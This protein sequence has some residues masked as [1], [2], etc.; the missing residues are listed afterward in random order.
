MKPRPNRRKNSD[1]LDNAPLRLSEHNPFDSQ[2][3]SPHGGTR[4]VLIFLGL[5][6]VAFLVFHNVVPF[7]T[8]WLW[9][10]EVGY[11]NVFSTT[12][13]AKSGLFVVFGGLFFALFYGNA[14]W[15]RRLAPEFADKFLMERAGVEWGRAIQRYIGVALLAL[16]AFISLWAGRLAAENW[17]GWLEFRHGVPF[18]ASDF[19]FGNDIG[20][21]VFRL[22]FLNFVYT[23]ALGAL[24]LTLVAVVAIHI[25]DHAI[26]SFAGLPDVRSGVRTQILLLAAAAALVQAWG[27]RLGAYDLLHSDNGLFTGAGYVDIHQRLFAL[28]VQSLALLAAGVA[29]LAA[30]RTKGFRAPLIAVGVWLFALV[31]LG[32]IWPGIVQKT[33][34][35]PNQFAR[36]KEYMAR[37]IAATRAGFGLTNVRRVDDFAANANLTSPQIEA[38]R[39][40]LDNVRLWDYPYLG[41]VYG[42]QQ[43]IKPYYKFENETIG[44][45]NAPNIDIDRYTIGGRLRQVMLAARELDSGALPES[46]QTWQNQK[47]AYT[48]GYGLVMSPVNRT[49]EGSPDYFIEGFPPTPRGE[50]SGL[51]IAQ[52]EIYYGQLAH[53]P[54]YVNTQQPEFD[55]PSGQNAGGGSAAQ[56]H[57]TNYKG[58]GGIEIGDSYWRKLA[59][60]SRL[61]DWNLMLAS[62]LTPRTRVL[63]RRDIRDRLQTVA[64]FV[65]QD[66]DPYLVVTP[67]TG[68]LLW[69]MDCYTMSDRYPYSTPQQMM[70]SVGTYI[71]PNY[72]RNSVKATV[73][74]YDGTM[75]LYVSDPNDPIARTYDRIYPGLLKPMSA[76]PLTLRA[77][78]R[79]PEDLFRLQR[80]VYAVYHVDDPRVFYLKEDVWAVPTE[81]NVD[82]SAQPA[83]PPAPGAFSA[84]SPALAQMEP[85]YIIMHLP[86][87]G[88]EEEKRLRGLEGKENADT[89][90]EPRAANHEPRTTAEFVLMSPLAPIKKEDQN[91]LGWMCAR[92]DGDSYGQLVLYRFGQQV[93]VAGPSQIVQLINSDR[94]IS[95]QLSLL[96]Q[97]GSTAS[98]GNMLVIPIDQSLLYIAPLYVESSASAN[99]LPRLQKVVVAFGTNVAMEDTLE[100]ALASLFT[101]LSSKEQPAIAGQTPA[102]VGQPSTFATPANVRALIE[103]AGQ[104]YDAARQKLKQEDLAG[105]AEQ[106]K[107][108]GQT[109]SDLRKAAG[110]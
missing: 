64:P 31:V 85:Y 5:L 59:F 4:R 67:D 18:G 99:K 45:Q 9:F 54:V 36:E 108:F 65:Q 83:T 25:A 61:G 17:S 103:Q 30:L 53:Q 39:D 105:Y 48:H 28:N 27:T 78:V 20:F 82:Q 56:D 32:G 10:R 16:S 100:R 91:I 42:Q 70:V 35:D 2:G 73:D 24:L 14:A 40:T 110:K 52:P 41:K 97:G 109:L 75:N 66:A 29:C 47:L 98:L 88:T 80:A 87:L 49:L 95:P 93:S 90:R 84:P 104:Q 11:T 76:M 33:S 102:V 57:Y 106:M 92:C 3:S 71:A 19:V 89:S 74:A 7:Y 101:G 15:A 72:I 13:L 94:V 68:R 21:Y 44:G 96:R 23:F 38:S 79:Y 62:N 63:F 26:E 69:M 43:T 46:A 37:N 107:Q 22:P 6:F 1:P 34:V 51:N 8:D 50:A 55:Y 77:H 12:V 86:D 60:A 58:R 81:P